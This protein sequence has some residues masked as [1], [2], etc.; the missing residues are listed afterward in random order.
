MDKQS[1]IGQL[2]LDIN[3]LQRQVDEFKKHPE[4]ITSAEWELFVQRLHLMDEYCRQLKMDAPAEKE[5][6]QR[7]EPVVIP[8]PHET[9]F[10]KTKVPGIIAHEI[11]EEKNI[12]SSVP[13]VNE[14]IKESLVNKE[15]PAVVR[16]E[17]EIHHAIPV[18]ET[19]S[20]SPRTKKHVA[21]IGGL[22]DD[23]LSVADQF[24]DEPSVA[25]RL[26]K[27]KS[28]KSVADKMQHKPVK[29]I[30]DAIGINEKFL[31][32]NEL[33]DGNLQDYSE[34]LNTLN[35]SADLQSAQEFIER[36]LAVRFKWS[37]DNE[38]VKNFR[39]LVAR[40]FVS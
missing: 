29:D 38:H 20:S 31:F 15:I 22:F 14:E 30:R 2:E 36:E 8:L 3:A 28:E 19:K 40:R 5:P 24:K 11:R 33:F 17:E 1:I 16:T 10:P 37:D 34:A 4:N 9:E 26:A 32:I 35:A 6:E 13:V 25:D 12:V 39:N 18:T 7:P 27:S 21:S 23:T